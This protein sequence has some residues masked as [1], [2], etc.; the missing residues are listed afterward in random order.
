M[1]CKSLV[2]LNKCVM[3]KTEELSSESSCDRYMLDMRSR[4]ANFFAFKQSRGSLDL[5]FNLQGLDADLKV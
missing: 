2:P 5:S 1:S 3:E 4:L